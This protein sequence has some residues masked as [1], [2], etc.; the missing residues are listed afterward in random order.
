MSEKINA[1]EMFDNEVAEQD[2]TMAELV[3]AIVIAEA[4]A[5]K[6]K[7]EASDLKQSLIDFCIAQGQPTASGVVNDVDVKMRISNKMR[8]ERKKTASM[9]QVVQWLRDNNFGD[10]V[11]TEPY[12]ETPTIKSAV[13]MAIDQD[14]IKI[15]DIPSSLFSIFNQNCLDYLSGKTKAFETILAGKEK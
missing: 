12:A 4:T 9:E 13:L 6:H 1:D 7:K 3:T 5:Q 11:K 8:F 15:E 2:V 10:I 14:V